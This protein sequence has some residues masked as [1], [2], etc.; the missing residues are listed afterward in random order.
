MQYKSLGKLH[1]HV[2]AQWWGWF[3]CMSECR[4]VSRVGGVSVRLADRSSAPETNPCMNKSIKP[5]L[6]LALSLRGVGVGGISGGWWGVSFPS[7]CDSETDATFPCNEKQTAGARG[8]L[9]RDQ[10]QRPRGREDR[11]RGRGWLWIDWDSYSM[12]RTELVRRQVCGNMFC[13]GLVRHVV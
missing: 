12:F 7:V 13:G 8:G 9:E 4:G 1:T 5:C 11:G 2:C 6:S 3:K 10:N